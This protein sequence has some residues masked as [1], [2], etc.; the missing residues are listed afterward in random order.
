MTKLVCLCVY[1]TVMSGLYISPLFINSPCVLE[2]ENIP[3]KPK[4]FAHRGASGVR[5]FV[6][7][8]DFLAHW[9][10]INLTLK[11]AAEIVKCLKLINELPH[12]K[13]NKPACAP[14]KD[15]DQPGHP[16]SLIRVFTVRMKKAWVLSYPL[17]A[18]RRL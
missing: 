15:S 1:F 9:L 4:I 7:F 6:S 13:T 17:S 11:A 8:V 12:E 3:Q 10:K 5:S 14:S 2:T 18:Q 16:P